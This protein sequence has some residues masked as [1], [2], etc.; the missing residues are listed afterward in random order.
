[1]NQENY[2]Y[3]T[4]RCTIPS[5]TAAT[6]AIQF[7]EIL[8]KEYD[9]CRGIA[10][11]EISDG[12]IQGTSLGIKHTKGKIFQD[13]TTVK[14]YLAGDGLK[15]GDRY[16]QFGG[17]IDNKGGREILLEFYTEEETTSDAIYDVVFQLV[18]EII[19]PNN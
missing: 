9:L 1:M 18:N 17:S 2:K 10:V 13:P 14:D 8:D 7:K 11:Y 3:Q 15:F 4:K 6:D 12:G 5:G 16:K 19:T